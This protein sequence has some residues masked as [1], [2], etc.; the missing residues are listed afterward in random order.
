M[1]T[2][3]DSSISILYVNVAPYIF[4]LSNILSKS[5]TK[6]FFSISLHAVTDILL[7]FILLLLSSNLM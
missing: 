6:S 7:P 5:V 2:L 1:L 3:S 4:I